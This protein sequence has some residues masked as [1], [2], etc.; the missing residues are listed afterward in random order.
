M[1]EKKIH[2]DNL[3]KEIG[4]LGA[5]SE[6]ISNEKTAPPNVV[7]G[8]SSVQ[9]LE[10]IGLTYE[11]MQEQLGILVI[12]TIAFMKSVWGKVSE[13]DNELAKDISGQK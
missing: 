6:K 1:A 8:G 4:S 9:M 11:K 12:E 2:L 5:L 3:E 10:N 7:G 13:K